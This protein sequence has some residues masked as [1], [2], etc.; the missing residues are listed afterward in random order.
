V[1]S[2]RLAVGAA[3]EQA[4]G[5]VSASDALIPFPDTVE[6]CASAGITAI[7]QTG[8]SIRDE[9]SVAVCDANDMVMVATGV[10]HFRH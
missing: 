10:R 6:V 7:I 5:A 8:G 2:A 9:E 3:G 4:R 1:T